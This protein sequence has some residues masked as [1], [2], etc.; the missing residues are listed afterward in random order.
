MKRLTLAFL[1]GLLA[2]CASTPKGA[3]KVRALEG[4]PSS[5]NYLTAAEL[6]K[7]LR[8][9]GGEDLEVELR[10]L[11]KGGRI[12]FESTRM[13]VSLAEQDNTHPFLSVLE[14]GKEIK[15]CDESDFDSK[16]VETRASLHDDPP[17]VPLKSNTVKFQC[18]LPRPPAGEFEVRLLD[19]DKRVIESYV[20]TPARPE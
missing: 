10:M 18:D 20:V 4:N 19:S 6:E 14:S 3:A 12:H 15:F 9:K 16:D 7:D 11:P 8:A 17:L 2:A 13:K 5:V 1:A